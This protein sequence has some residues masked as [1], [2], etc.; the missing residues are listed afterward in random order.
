MALPAR[1]EEYPVAEMGSKD[2]TVEMI[3]CA[4]NPSDINQIQGDWYND[5]SNTNNVSLSLIPGHTIK[6]HSQTP[7]TYFQEWAWEQKY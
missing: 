3:M 1:S 4:V 6:S 7:I 5:I 2:V